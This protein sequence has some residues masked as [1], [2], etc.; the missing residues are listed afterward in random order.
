MENTSKWVTVLDKC[1]WAWISRYEFLHSLFST[2]K[3]SFSVHGW[4]AELIYRG[5]H[6]YLESSLTTHFAKNNSGRSRYTH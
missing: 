3:G 5:D 2:G 4:K 1:T 6:K